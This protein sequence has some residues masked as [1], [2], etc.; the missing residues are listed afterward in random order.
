MQDTL[1]DFQASLLKDR[2][3]LAEAMGK[4][5]LLGK[6]GTEPKRR[7]TEE[8][9]KYVAAVAE[10]ERMKKECVKYETPDDYA[11]YGK[12]QRQI[13]KLE[14]ELKKLKDLADYS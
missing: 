6:T 10:I 9:K 8:E 5:S 14:K 4:T 1:K 13:L 11:K 3:E 12:M 7:K 2:P